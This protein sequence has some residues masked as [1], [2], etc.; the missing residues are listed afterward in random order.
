MNSPPM[1]YFFGDLRIQ[2]NSTGGGGFAQNC[3]FL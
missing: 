1:Y 2:K 3:N